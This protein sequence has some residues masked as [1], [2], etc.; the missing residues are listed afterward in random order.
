MSCDSCPGWSAVKAL[1][2]HAE[3]YSVQDCLKWQ[4]KLQGAGCEGWWFQPPFI[5]RVPV[6]CW[7]AEVLLHHSL[8]LRNAVLSCS[9]FFAIFF[10]L[11][12]IE[13][14]HLEGVVF[15]D[16]SYFS[17]CTFFVPGSITFLASK[18]HCCGYGIL[19]ENKYE[20]AEFNQFQYNELTKLFFKPYIITV[21]NISFPS[22]HCSEI[23]STTCA[24]KVSQILQRHQ[25]CQH[26]V[27]Y[28][29][30]FSRAVGTGTLKNIIRVCAGSWPAINTWNESKALSLPSHQILTGLLW[31]GN[32][33]SGSCII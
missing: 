18:W 30:H 12:E 31:V 6:S 16:T 13:F 26:S 21:P 1:G 4:V 33:S 19:K 25:S 22:S 2:N 28:R 17:N 8:R 15:N 3:D 27:L 20:L 14:I 9:C 23:R 11:W 10:H 32:G 7:F 29:T 5:G 24:L